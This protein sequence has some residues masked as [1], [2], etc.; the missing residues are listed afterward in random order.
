MPPEWAFLRVGIR[1]HQAVRP[2]DDDTMPDAR[3][4]LPTPPRV[5][6]GG[7]IQRGHP[8]GLV[9]LFGLSSPEPIAF[10]RL[11]TDDT[12]L[13]APSHIL[14]E[15][16][17]V[18][19]WRHFATLNPAGPGAATHPAQDERRWPI[20]PSYRSGQQAGQVDTHQTG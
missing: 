12:C 4:V 6:D 19:T 10:S 20:R 11:G 13:I 1:P 16:V 3:T 5:S 15:V 2:V 17:T 18:T 8:A 9:R 7:G 14:A